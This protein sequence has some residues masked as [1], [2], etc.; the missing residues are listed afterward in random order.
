M[1][2]RK[3][4]THR[5]RTT[6]KSPARKKT[7]RKRAQPKRSPAKKVPVKAKEPGYMV[8]LSEPKALR[9]DVL[10]TLRESIIFMQGYENFRKIQE[11][12]V[13][14]FATLKTQV[15]ELDLLITRQLKKYFPQG[16]LRA[17]TR[18][19]QFKQEKQQ[20]EEHVEIAP[21]TRVPVTPI[22]PVVEPEPV[23]ELNELESQLQDIES[24]LQNIR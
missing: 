14:L 21:P 3:K 1:T 18:S 22:M 23:N 8:Q 12:K 6:K 17:V 5:K 11:E 2:A 24:Q 20:Q 4:T 15:K 7:T 16:K 9:K 10:E 19:E 13:L